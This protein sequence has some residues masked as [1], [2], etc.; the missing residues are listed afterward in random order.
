MLAHQ[1]LAVALLTLHIEWM[2]QRHYVDSVKDAPLDPQFASLLRH[3]WMEEAQHAKLDTLLVEALARTFG[4]GQIMRAIDEYL[5]I[6]GLLDSGLR[7]Q[8]EM[9]VEALRLATG[10]VLTESE[11]SRVHRGAAASPALDV[12]RLGH[13]PSPVPRH[14]RPAVARRPHPPGAGRPGVLLATSP[15]GKN[16][17]WQPPT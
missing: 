11:R 2:T 3:H 7:Q 16:G 5:E 17:A 15:S 10:R 12:H 4:E 1:P 8:V 9:D 14:G 13:H 6:G